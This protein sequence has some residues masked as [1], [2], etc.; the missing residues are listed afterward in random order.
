MEA[1]I[2]EIKNEAKKRKTTPRMA[3][4][5]Y[6]DRLRRAGNEYVRRRMAAGL[7]QAEIARELGL[8]ETTIWRWAK[9]TTRSEAST[10]RQRSSFKPVA[11]VGT[12]RGRVEA[13]VLSVVTPQ[14]YRVEGLDVTSAAALLRELG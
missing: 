2:A 13:Q 1:L 11:I 14:G 7:R 4:R 10:D 9:T 12:A 6:P 3:N 5:P 8:S